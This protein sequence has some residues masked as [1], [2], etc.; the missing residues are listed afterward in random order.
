MSEGLLGRSNTKGSNK[1]DFDNSFSVQ[2]QSCS[3]CRTT[4]LK[5]FLIRKTLVCIKVAFVRPFQDI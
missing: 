3:L 2:L 1:K 5:D 4:D